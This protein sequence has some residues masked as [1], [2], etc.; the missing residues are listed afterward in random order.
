MCFAVQCRASLHILF[1]FCNRF[2]DLIFDKHRI[3]QNIVGS[4]NHQWQRRS[5]CCPAKHCSLM[6]NAVQHCTTI[7]QTFK[8]IFRLWPP[9]NLAG[10]QR[11]HHLCLIFQDSVREAKARIMEILGSRGVRDLECFY[12]LVTPVKPLLQP[13][14]QFCS[15]KMWIDTIKC[16]P[17]QRNSL[18][19]RLSI[20]D[21]CL[22][23]PRVSH[24]Q[25]YAH[26]ACDPARWWMGWWRCALGDATHWAAGSHFLRSTIEWHM[27]LSEFGICVCLT[28][29]IHIFK[30]MRF[31]WKDS[32]TFVTEGI[33][34][35]ILLKI[36]E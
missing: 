5:C 34:I 19:Q 31:I 27:N 29:C 25:C 17:M 3:I 23:M 20:S 26:V 18:M 36:F 14:D 22:K 12:C 16:G 13:K 10:N 4:H 24:E 11:S 7:L 6:V 33:I 9:I 8:C 35:L 15:L 30:F 32:V 28:S 2:W 21:C 1:V